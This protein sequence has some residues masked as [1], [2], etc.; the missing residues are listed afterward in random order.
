[1]QRPFDAQRDTVLGAPRLSVSLRGR[2]VDVAFWNPTNQRAV[3]RLRHRLHSCCHGGDGGDIVQH[4]H[5]PP[6][7]H[8]H[9]EEAVCVQYETSQDQI[10]L[11]PL[12]PSSTSSSTSTSSTSNSSTSTTSTSSTSSTSTSSS[13]SSTSSSSSTSP[14]RCCVWARAVLRGFPPSA[15]SHR[16]CITITSS[17]STTDAAPRVSA[18]ALLGVFLLS[19]L[20]S[21]LCCVGLVAL[22]SLCLLE[23]AGFSPP[24]ILS[25]P[26]P[27]SL[28]GLAGSRGEEACA[29]FRAPITTTL[30]MADKATPAAADDDDAADDVAADDDDAADDDSGCSVYHV[31]SRDGELRAW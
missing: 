11:S 29:L 6:H 7:H 8:H 10:T 24:W 17:I 2:L 25:D 22:W 26:L 15:R 5:P 27:S 12:T 28:A 16:H 23:T 9:Q 14:L 18:S 4:H 19:A 3:S 31:L 21:C 20:V 13:T 30:T 1:M